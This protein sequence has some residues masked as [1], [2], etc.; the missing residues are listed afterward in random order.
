MVEEGQVFDVLL[1]SQNDD[2]EYDEV[3][4]QRDFDSW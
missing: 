2:F 1:E 3:A 4:V